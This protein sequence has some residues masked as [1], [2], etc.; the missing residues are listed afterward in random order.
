MGLLGVT[1]PEEYGGLG[2]NY[3]SYVTEDGKVHKAWLHDIQEKVERDYKKEYYTWFIIS[4]YESLIL[5]FYSLKNLIILY[6]LVMIFFYLSNKFNFKDKKM[7]PEINN[8]KALIIS[9]LLIQFLSLI[10][11]SVT[12]I[13]YIRALST[14]SIFF[15]PSIFTF[16]ILYFFYDKTKKI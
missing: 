11:T 6:I 2:T 9:I 10:L 7:L 1:I 3:V 14:Q 5:L 4:F 16:I 13:P 8:I 12:N 15:V